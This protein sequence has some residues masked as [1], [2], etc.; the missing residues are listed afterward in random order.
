[1]PD[2]EGTST[3]PDARMVRTRA[4]LCGALLRLLEEKPFD[5]VT[6]REITRAADVGYAT[7]FRRYPDKEALLND[8]AAGQITDL[9]KRTTPIF[10]S[11]DTRAAALALA[12]FVDEHHKLWSALLTGG[13]AGI[14]REEFIRQA[15][16]A[17]G[18]PPVPDGWLPAE[19]RVVYAVGGT[20]DILAW[21]LQQK[22]RLSIERIAE[23]VDR[24]A[25]IP[26]LV[27]PQPPT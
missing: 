23:I 17:S 11:D 9:L 10:S 20:I 24:L 7:F 25:I 2:A 14:L 13:A 8:L 21:W 5:Q 1:M 3:A 22:P 12:T 18:G 16:Q 6:V 26:T 4:A 19:L 15:K 27:D